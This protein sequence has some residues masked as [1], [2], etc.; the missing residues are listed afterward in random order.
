[1]VAGTRY[2]VNRDTG[3]GDWLQ[4]DA[5]M[6]VP[7]VNPH[8]GAL[9]SRRKQ[10]ELSLRSASDQRWDQVQDGQSTWL[11]QINLP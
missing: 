10:P 7:H 4:V 11:F 2:L 5:P 1:M 3:L 9:H 8:T 6:Y